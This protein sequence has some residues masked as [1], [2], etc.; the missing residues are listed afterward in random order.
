M[1][2]LVPLLAVGLVL[3][4]CELPSD[5][6]ASESKA[7]ERSLS[8]QVSA[9][10]TG[11]AT[12]DPTLGAPACASVGPTCDSGELLVGRANLGPEP[13]APNTVGGACADGTDGTYG[14]SASLERL[15]VSRSD[16]T[17]LAV[18]KEV[19]LQATVRAST[20]Y[21]AEVLDFYAAP[22]ASSPS[23]TLVKTEW[24]SKSGLQ[25]LSTSYV[26]PAGSRQVLRGVY[27]RLGENLS[28]CMPGSLNDHDD[29]VFEVALEPDSLPPSVALTIPSEGAIVRGYYPFKAEASD[30]FGVQ[31]VEFYDG[32]ALIGTV[33]RSPYS[34]YWNSRAVANGPHTLTAR[35]Y[36]VAGNI[37]LSTPLNVLVD[38]DFV[39]PQ[40]AFLT[41][42]EGATVGETVSLE[43]NASDDRGLVNVDFYVARDTGGNVAFRHIGSANAPPYR[44][45]WNARSSPDGPYV[46]QAIAHDSAGNVSPEAL[47]HVVLENDLIPPA[48]AITAPTSGA[49]LSGTVSIEASAS[50]NRQIVRVEFYVDG[51][52]VGFDTTAPYAVSWDTAAMFTGSHTL[53]SRAYDTAGYSTESAPVTVQ[54][55]NPGNVRYD[56]GLKAPRCDTVKDRCDTLT[57]VKGRGPAGPERYAPNTLDGCIDGTRTDLGEAIQRIRVLREDGTP[58]AEGKRVRIE[59]D[60]HSTYDA[61][62]YQYLELFSAANATQP[63]WTHITS[64]KLTTPGAQT[65]S[66][67]Y[68][69]PAGGLQA[70]RA[71]FGL[72]LS[73]TGVPCGTEPAD[74][75]WNDRDDVVFPVGQEPDTLPPQVALTAPAPQATV[76]GTVAVTAVASDNFGVVAVDFYDG[77]TLLGT[78]TS[79]PF[80]LSWATRSGP[81]GSHTLIARARDL[82]GNMALSQPVTVVVDN[83]LV[84]PT[85]AITS[86][87]PGTLIPGTVELTVNATDDRA[88]TRVELYSG[89]RLLV[90][91][92]SAPYR[93]SWDTRSEWSGTHVLTA[94]AYDAAGNVG[95]SEEVAVLVV[96][97]TTPPA[98]SITSPTASAAVAGTV[99]ISANATDEFGVQRV[100][101]LID[102]QM[103]GT[104][105]SAPY[106]FTWNTLTATIGNHTLTA[107]ATDIHG[108][109]ATSP[110]VSVKVDNLPPS[111]ALTSPASGT[112]LVGVVSLAAEATDTTGVTRVDFFVDGALLASDTSAPYSVTWDS[113]GWV[114]GSH[115]LYARAYD[116]LGHMAVSPELTVNTSQPTSAVFDPVLRVPTCASTERLCDTLLLVKGRDGSESNAPNTL[117]GSC[118]D[119]AELPESEKIH[120]IK[121]Y[122]TTGSTFAQGQRVRVEVHVNA[123]NTATDALDLFYTS[124]ANTPS[125]THLATLVPSATGTQVLAAEYVLPAG[126]LQ[127][128]RAQFRVGGDASSACSTGARDDHDDLAFLVDSDP[129]VSIT[130]PAHNAQVQGTV[131]VTATAADNYEVRRVEFYVDGI[132]IGS[133]VGAPYQQNWNSTNMA[134]GAHTLTAK[135]YDAGGRVGTSASVVVYTDNTPPTATLTAPAQG[136]LL[137]GSAQLT[138]TAS[139]AQGVARVEF[140]D[141]ATLIGT[142]TASPYALSW[143]TASAADGAHTLSVKA[144]DIAGNVRTSVSVGVTVDNTGPTTALTAPAPDAH[145]RKGLMLSASASDTHGVSKIEYY[146]DATL[147]GTYSST[148]SMHLWDTQGVADGAHTLT[149]KAYDSLGNV[150][151]SAGVAVIVDNT[152]PT[153]AITSPTQSARVGGTVQFTATATDN[154]AVDRVEFYA[155]ERLVGTATSAP[156]SVSWNTTTE[157]NYS[158][159]LRT[160]VYDRAGN[161][162]LSAPAYYVTVDNLAPTVAI[163]SPANGASLFLSATIQVS[164]SDNT[165]ITQVVFYDGTKVLGT[166]T[167]APYSFSW[168]LL[169]VTKGNHTLTAKAYDAAGNVTT[170]APIT[171]KVN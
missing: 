19:T 117:H 66:A 113:A 123:V 10:S 165:G 164:A 142:D 62:R 112:T 141:G 60:V 119:G 46:L 59:V 25:V 159:E 13:H 96:R 171:V 170:S 135:A 157:A 139:D 73:P 104:S 101:F 56:P 114:N 21:W 134:N 15:S 93:Y 110:G 51:E 94:R 154:Q 98:V 11:N 136:A 6:D 70:V 68:I 82:A 120:R 145:L 143:N 35:A 107:R 163:T 84:V 155:G 151:T 126:F 131:A 85:V 168:G 71:K 30:N 9:E 125:W 33:T 111:V 144:Y 61:W 37:A 99:T 7:L 77:Q 106:S 74:G 58:M 4:A 67:E 39:P 129:T 138:A 81:S 161:Y 72:F 31:R 24:P 49:S 90:T 45:A 65:L 5:D 41:P 18:G 40:V 166:D 121:V 153:T 130:S 63:A 75:S 100:E 8:A 78:D 23:W 108:N 17:A 137:R 2:T 160:K 147:L 12:F 64:I 69:L 16:G 140:Y 103:V 156:Y 53:T 149:V 92:P 124:N 169:S 28:P 89:T 122:S 27:R 79:A 52:P 3:A 115:T 162:S 57:L 146:V 42:V 34:L 32:A 118:A 148:S 152:L 26:L 132:L 22:D 29:L 91:L 48:T 109:A 50:D 36:D 116:G 167:S 150:T 128:V 43:V 14:T 158:I 54:T 86:P 102:G 47:V 97:D 76:S 1:R 80:S 133:D 95:I 55:N 88:V 20:N 87:A 127:A 44:V 105:T 83:D 38:N